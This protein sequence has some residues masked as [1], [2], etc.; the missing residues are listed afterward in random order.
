MGTRDLLTGEDLAMGEAS[1][2]GQ[3]FTSCSNECFH[4]KV[5]L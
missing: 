2:G 1:G 4:V 5:D 3:T